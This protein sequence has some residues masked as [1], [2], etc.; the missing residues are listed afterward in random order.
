MTPPSKPAY[1]RTAPFERDV[2]FAVSWEVP[3]PSPNVVPLEAARVALHDDA[4]ERAVLGSL[5]LEP[6][7]FK[8]VTV[9]VTAADFYT[10]AH[11]VIFEAIEACIAQDPDA[12]LVGV[13]V[14][15]AALRAR[16]KLALIGGASYLAQL[17][18][19]TVTTAHTAKHATRVAQ[20]AAQRRADDANRRASLAA[21]QGDTAMATTATAEALE[22]FRRVDAWEPPIPLGQ[23][24]GP[25]WPR[26]VFDG[27]LDTFVEAVAEETQTDPAMVGPMVLAA[28]S[29]AAMRKFVV[30][31]KP[32][33]YAE[34]INLYAAVVAGP[35][36]RKSSVRAHTAGPI[37]TYERDEVAR[38]KED[39]EVAR[40]KYDALK[41]RVEAAKRQ[42][43]RLEDDRREEAEAQLEH[44][45]RELERTPDPWP[46]RWLA[47]DA[48]PEALT[49]LLAQHGG[50]IAVLSPEG[51]ELF[52]LMAGRYQDAGA[53]NLGVYLCGHTAE[54]LRISRMKR[55]VYIDRP[56]LTIG[57][58]T[59]PETLA[60]LCKNGLRGRGLPARFLFTV[61][62]SR[63]GQ[64]V[65][66]PPLMRPEHKLWYGD[67]LCK[68]LALPASRDDHDRETPHALTF[69]PEAEAHY[70]K[71]H[72]WLEPQLAPRGEL[73]AIAEWAG[74]L[75]GATVRIAGLLHLAAHCDAPAPW[76]IPVAG[77]TFTRA[78]A[79]G[80]FFI[81]HAK[82]AFGLMEDPPEIAAAR[83]ILAWLERAKK[84]VVS[85]RD[86]HRGA[87][88]CKGNREQILDPALG[89]LVTHHYLVPIESE[90]NRGRGRPVERYR[91]NPAVL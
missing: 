72:D 38:C 81:G 59:Q 66:H 8:E 70:A 6:A 87:L 86:I 28:L 82:V 24:A 71:M 32:G 79:L 43:A 54:S 88:R 39:I 52:A 48:T 15:A 18:D 21:R 20:L 63:A 22:H 83:K 17:T 68:V 31:P 64:R 36:E 1:G 10:P 73:E 65:S 44:L 61:P 50:R 37:E 58:T 62:R 2:P 19:E 29:T 46:P 67:T 76:E 3:R 11:A 55:E 23:T 14:L 12:P 47:D 45:V 30:R 49:Q 13:D 90:A 27:S 9:K 40:A 60:T 5:L 34:P 74:K 75:L 91:V 4:A 80:E 85:T 51:G 77:D 78:A 25:P 26:G 56:A 42:V 89:L 53:P 69:G 84:P 7:R 41:Q 33:L 57:V 16:G 35:A